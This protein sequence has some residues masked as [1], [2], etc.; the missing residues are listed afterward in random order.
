[1]A[2][3]ERHEKAPLYGKTLTKEKI[4]SFNEH[5]K[6]SKSFCKKLLDEKESLFFF[7]AAEIVVGEVIMGVASET[8]KS[9]DES[10][11]GTATDPFP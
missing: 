11:G 3:S 10:V 2:G 8:S 7:V 4:Q 1:M 6:D 5:T 9:V